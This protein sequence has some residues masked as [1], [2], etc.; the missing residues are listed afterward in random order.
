MPFWS[1]N[2]YHYNCHYDWPLWVE[3]LVVCEPAYGWDYHYPCHTVYTSPW[4]RSIISHHSLCEI[5]CVDMSM[6]DHPRISHDGKSVSLKLNLPSYVDTTKIRYT[7]YF[8]YIIFSSSLTNR[9]LWLICLY[10]RTS[11]VC[12]LV[13]N[14]IVPE[15]I[16]PNWDNSHQWY[17]NLL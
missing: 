16:W 10:V 17:L 11:C 9:S 14:F 2:P 4:P 12:L 1:L 3:P 15:F 7:N 8:L 6:H 13:S 5:D